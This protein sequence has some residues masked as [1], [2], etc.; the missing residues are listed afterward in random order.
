MRTVAYTALDQVSDWVRD[1]LAHVPS[2]WLVI[3][4]G[5]LVAIF[6]FGLIRKLLALVVIVVIIV[7]VVGGLW[8]YAGNTIP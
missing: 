4:A 2:F 5:V 1:T 8:I 6:I 3:A 7:A